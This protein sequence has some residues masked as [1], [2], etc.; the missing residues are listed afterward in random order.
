M[1]KVESFFAVSCLFCLLIL[2]YESI[3]GQWLFRGRLAWLR[4]IATNSCSTT[5][6]TSLTLPSQ[7]LVPAV[8]TCTEHQMVPEYTSDDSPKCTFSSSA[9]AKK[10]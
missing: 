1:S 4:L 5:T 2:W 9:V 3:Q 10:K 8:G 6:Y 7:T